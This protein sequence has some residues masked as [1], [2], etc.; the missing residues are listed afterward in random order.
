M[1]EQICFVD[2][3]GDNC[4]VT[5]GLIQDPVTENWFCP[6]H[7]FR[8]N[9]EGCEEMFYA[10]RKA[11]GWDRCEFCNDVDWC[12]KHTPECQICGSRAAM[13]KDCAKDEE[14]EHICMHCWA[15]RDEC[16]MV[17]PA[18][19]DSKLNNEVDE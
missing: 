12:G 19:V 16:A 4:G 14:Y 11:E 2:D 8:C 18:K 17:K 9:K 7:V 1:A 6:D 13:C 3:I 15:I 5:D 10:F